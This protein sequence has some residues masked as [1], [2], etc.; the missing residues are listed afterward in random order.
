MAIPDIVG[1]YQT[2]L[3]NA[4]KALAGQWTFLQQYLPEISK[5]RLGTINLRLSIPLLIQNPDIATPAIDWWRDHPPECFRLTRVQMEASSF[6]TRT[7]IS[8][9]GWIYEAQFS[10]YASDPYYIE[11][12]APYVN[13]PSTFIW[14]IVIPSS[15]RVVETVL[16]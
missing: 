16:I 4:H 12:I 5:C 10:P 2:G 6:D 15:A 14:H 8:L 3:G 11:V 13:N 9:V 7:Q 1:K